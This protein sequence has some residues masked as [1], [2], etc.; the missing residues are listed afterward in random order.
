MRW[1]DIEDTTNLFSTPFIIVEQSHC[2]QRN[3][4]KV[5]EHMAIEVN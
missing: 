1:I 5:E 4:G 3:G 2:A